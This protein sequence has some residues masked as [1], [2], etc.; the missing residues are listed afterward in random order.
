MDRKRNGIFLKVG[1]SVERIPHPTAGS[2]MEEESTIHKNWA[3][4]L[5]PP[6]DN[7]AGQDQNTSDLLYPYPEKLNS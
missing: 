7:L 2:G 3:S 5:L 4:A 1:N 6:P